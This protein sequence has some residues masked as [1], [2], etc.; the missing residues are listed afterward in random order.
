MST[1][2]EIPEKISEIPEALKPLRE[3]LLANLVM[4]AQI[5][6]PTREEAPRVRFLLDRFGEA[7]LSDAAAD[8][9]GN[10]VGRVAGKRGH[11]TI[12]LV[13]HLDTIFPATLSHDVMVEADRVIGPGVGDNALG[14]AIVSLMPAVLEGVCV[15]GMQMGRL[16]FFSIGTV[17]A[18][19]TCAV[20]QIPE[21]SRSYGSESAL[22]VLNHIINRILGIATPSRPYTRIKM[23]KMRAGLYYDV[24]PD[25]AELGLEVVSHS[26]E[27]IEQICSEI[28]DI[29]SEMSARHAVDAR[30]DSFFSTKAGGIPFS[31]PLV[32][33]VMEVMGQ[34]GIEPDQG[35]SPSELSELISRNIPAVTLG[36][37]RGT[38]NRKTEPDYVLIDPILTGVAQLVG[39][40]LAI[41]EGVCDEV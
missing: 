15:E 13:S 3:R 11:R 27:M 41:D 22:V 33:G 7:G 34:L 31:H 12:L 10:A 8:D 36:I 16:N 1:H 28:S 26:D 23:G 6:A 37:T 38:K 19:I 24:E 18:D 30:L 5:P 40:M 39:V 35:H 17:R 2:V 32:K 20:R 4:I 29:V 14:A 21:P 9:A 25:H